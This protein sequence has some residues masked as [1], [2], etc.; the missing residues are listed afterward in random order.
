MLQHYNCVRVKVSGVVTIHDEHPPPSSSS[1]SN[2]LYCGDIYIYISGSWNEMIA[3]Q[4]KWR[5][6]YLS[7]QCDTNADVLILF[8]WKKNYEVLDDNLSIIVD[9][10]SLSILVQNQDGI[11]FLLD[12]ESST[13]HG[14]IAVIIFLLELDVHICPELNTVN[15]LIDESHFQDLVFFVDLSYC[16]YFTIS[17]SNPESG[18]LV[19]LVYS[20]H[21][22]P[23]YY[24]IAS[25]SWRDQTGKITLTINH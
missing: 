3:A 19:N 15:I 24:K 6:I 21:D 20:R 2:C 9:T 5:L 25:L 10:Y 17:V 1:S 8:C 4:I 22:L 16:F 12:H 7:K 18:T 11:P 14:D 13:Y 23:V